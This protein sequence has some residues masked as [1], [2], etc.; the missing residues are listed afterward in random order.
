MSWISDVKSE[1]KTLEISK[2]KL[3]SFGLLVGGV[4]LLISIWILWPDNF[5]LSAGY[6]FGHFL[7]TVGLFLFLSGLL[8]PQTLKNVYKIWM[9]FAFAL[10]WL[11]SRILITILF[12][13]VVTPVSLL[14]RLCRK[15][16]LDLIFRDNK[17]SYWIRREKDAVIDYKKMY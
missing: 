2:K 12:F 14:A 5:S 4:F 15:K 16:F 17:N 11:V 6:S 9:G 7:L 13:L 1:L 10:G 8:F 3:R